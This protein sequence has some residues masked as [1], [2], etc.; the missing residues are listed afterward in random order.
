MLVLLLLIYV[1][2]WFNKVLFASLSV[3]KLKTFEFNK[4]IE[5]VFRLILDV[6]VVVFTFSADKSVVKLSNYT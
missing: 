3:Y 1:V 6:L 4:V 5:L 2:C